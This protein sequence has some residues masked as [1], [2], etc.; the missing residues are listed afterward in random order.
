MR[1]RLSLFVWLLLAASL[2]LPAQA[3][4]L[5]ALEWKELA[6]GVWV[7]QRP[8]PM[9]YPVVCNTVIVEGRDGIL[10]FDAGGFPAQGE[11]VFAKVKALTPKPVTHIV[12]SHWHGDH[13]RGI[14]PLLDAFPGAKVVSHTFTRDA[15][16]GAP[17]QSIFKAERDGGAL[18]TAE[19]VKKAL[20]DDKAIDGSSISAAERAYWE[21]F[22]ADAELHQAEIMRMTIVAPTI[23]FDR[24]LDIDLGGRTVQLR[25][26][27]W[28]NTKGD[29]VMT[30]GA[31]RIV[32]A[33]DTVVAPVP[34]G[35]GSYPE[36]WAS[37]LKRIKDTRYVTLI[38]GHGPLLTD[39]S[40][41]DL[42]IETLQSV[43]AQVGALAAEGKSLDA[44]REAVDFS[45]VEPRFTHGDP[46]LT[47]FF[48]LFFKQPIVQAAYNVAK[49]IENEKL[50][51]DAGAAK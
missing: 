20:A 39:T 34:Y 18:K 49:G 14:Q 27:G 5:F 46:I 26:F 21:R 42:L 7:G 17:M 11:Q 8:D 36:S 29:V 3:E 12:I 13:N 23:T 15:M 44:V 28:G 9:R 40:Y 31:E 6:R 45:K 22:I 38:P 30:L 24:E 48:S 43:A 32:A 1:A 47:R 35:F 16:L 33:G 37:V 10:V 19:S 41:V 25:H 51:E 4:G 2:S 50:T